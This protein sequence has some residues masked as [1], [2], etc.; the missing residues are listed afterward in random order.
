M[1]PF[2]SANEKEGLD[3]AI[4]D[5]VDRHQKRILLQHAKRGNVNGLKNFM[6]VFLETNQL[7]FLW[8]RRRALKASKAVSKIMKN[9]CIV[10]VEDDLFDFPAAYLTTLI[11]MQ[12]GNL[13]LLAETLVS[14]EVPG[15]LRAA[16]LLLQIIRCED[17]GKTKKSPIVY[18]ENMF[19]K[20]ASTLKPLS[21]NDVDSK[22]VGRALYEYLMIPDTEKKEWLAY[23]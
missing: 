19:E 20:M 2:S 12:K 10:A 18:L 4:C 6:D 13:K 9:I 8:Y 23:L 14:Y 1:T 22:Q 21:L 7:I 15:H 5:F 16:L 17:D 11:K 3:K